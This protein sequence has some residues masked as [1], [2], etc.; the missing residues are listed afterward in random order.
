MTEKKPYYTLPEIADWDEKQK[1]SLPT[2]QRGFVWKPSQIENLWDSLLRGYPVGAFVL[3]NADD[4]SFHILDGQQRA[5]AICLGF[6]KETFRDSQE[7]YKV[8]VDLEPPKIEDSRKYIF[9]VI[10]KS[11]PWGYRRQENTKT[12]T[13]E[14]IRKAMD[15]YEEVT[16]PL[17]VPL[18]QFF[19]YDA[20]LPVPFHYF[21]NAP[22]ENSSVEEAL[23]FQKI[24]QEYKHWPIIIESWRK[25]NAEEL[26]KLS[27]QEIE[28]VL[29]AK[30]LNIYHAVQE[31]LHPDSGQKIPA[32][33]MNLDK[34][35]H[36]DG[37]ETEQ[38]AD[39]VENLFVRLNSGGTQLSGE[40]LNYSILKAHLKREVQDEIEKAC[41]QLFKPARFI[42]VAFRLYQQDI[43]EGNQSDALTMRIKP[44]QFQRA[45]SI[46]EEEDK[47][48]KNISKKSFEE[49]I[50][51]IIRNKDY[52]EMNLLEYTQGVL[53][54]KATKAKHY[55]LPFLI[56]S[57]IADVAPELMFLLLYRIKYKN[58][59]FSDGDAIAEKQHRT[60]LGILTLFMWFGKGGNFKDHSKLLANIWVAA[61]T[62]DKER[63]WSSETLDRAYIN[64]VLL[65]FPAFK[66]NKDEQGLESIWQYN[67]SEKSNVLNRFENDTR[68]EYRIFLRKAIYI[69][70]LILYAQRHFIESYFNQAQYRLE[71]T[72]LPF[73][74][75]HISPNDFVRNKKSVPSIVKDWY[76]TNGNFR[77]WPYALNR[78]DKDKSPAYKLNPLEN[79]EEGD[80]E[81]REKWQQFISQNKNLISDVKQV[82][83]RLS[84]WS[85]CTAEW[86][87]LYDTN[88]RSGWKP[89]IL[90]IIHRNVELMREW[91]DQLS[92]DTLRKSD[93]LRIEHLLDKRK[94]NL[95]PI[96]DESIDYWFY[97]DEYQNLISSEFIIDN[98]KLRF[99][100]ICPIGD[101]D[102]LKENEIEFGLF[103]SDGNG[104]IRKMKKKSTIELNYDID[105]FKWVFENFTLISGHSKS[106]QVLVAEM[107]G[108][109][110][111][112]PVNL[113]DKEI[114]L[115]TF[116][117]MLSTKFKPAQI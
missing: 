38:A 79:C 60:M 101:Y 98:H 13:A 16:D 68:P 56:Y 115:S 82:P 63:F 40:E 104:Y 84:E 64:E 39:E 17:N 109:L 105:E 99:Y 47:E 54:Y 89:V 81:L 110:L 29:D 52:E 67:I 21:L 42:T 78:M 80:N 27:E 86:N 112:L 58:D 69:R 73:D 15:M 116:K 88:M 113:E 85:F 9:R 70:D 77:A 2:V 111:K 117:E 74:W 100:L 37:Q 62:L 83:Q 92:I 49:F 102:Y 5:T 33:F 3:S 87:N 8:F 108:W 114:I 35:M 65:P 10:T 1:V 34:L 23:L 32:L 31:M 36:S 66:R 71:D 43:K 41:K 19:P 72:S 22:V 18:E 75:D 48:G 93:Q 46:K 7:Y 24:K 30:I 103:E 97:Q 4:Q 106:F 45:I 76:Q 6:A 12:L 14:N 91:Y 95:L 11:H 51:E 57:K 55:G 53:E 61:T 28:N 96:G 59:R 44:K 25:S 90:Q 20:K 94:W 50:L 26:N 107:M